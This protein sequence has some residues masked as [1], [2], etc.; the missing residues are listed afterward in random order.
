[1]NV[2]CVKV[3]YGAAFPQTYHVVAKTPKIAIN[4]AL[5]AARRDGL[6]RASILELKKLGPA[7]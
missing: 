1:M 2:F 6:E 5:Q 4:K 3:E 7:I